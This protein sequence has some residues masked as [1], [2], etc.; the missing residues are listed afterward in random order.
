MFFLQMSGFPGAGKSTLARL[1]AENTGAIVIDHDI[2][3]SALLDSLD[4]SIDPK[5]AGKMA[6]QIDWS[7]IDLH[8]SQ[9][10]SVILDSPC[11]YKEMIERGMDLATKHYADYK[12]VEC[13]LND[14]QEI[15]HRLKTRKRMKSQIQQV[16]GSEL[17][18]KRF[19][20]SSVKPPG[21]NFLVVK[22]DQPI[23]KYFN[24]VI[25]YVHQ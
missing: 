17:D 5:L 22:T 15:N 25:Q 24:K 14:Y 10:F 23:Q 21:G 12:Y 6:Y 3:K 19:V 20:D 1:I 7:L 9:G 13:Y 18:F 11:F 16:A 8:L 4:V 2:I